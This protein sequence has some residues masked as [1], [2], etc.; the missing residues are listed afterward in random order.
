MIGQNVSDALNLKMRSY[1]D[2][3][4]WVRGGSDAKTV[5]ALQWQLDKSLTRGHINVT[6]TRNEV[7]QASRAFRKIAERAESSP[8]NAWM[9]LAEQFCAQFGTLWGDIPTRPPHIAQGTSEDWLEELGS[10]LDAN[11][12]AKELRKGNRK[13]R[14]AD[15]IVFI[16]ETGKAV[17]IRSNGDLIPVP[18]SDE[19]FVRQLPGEGSPRE[20]R[21]PDIYRHG[22]DQQKLWA[23][24]AEIINVQLHDRLSLAI[25]P[26]QKGLPA[27]VPN[28][29]L[30]TMYARLW[31]DIVTSASDADLRPVRTCA[32]PGCGEAL[33]IHATAR[34]KYCSDNCRVMHHRLAT[35]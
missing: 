18:G 16:E 14:V 3:F 5:F 15:R 8:D 30:A 10:F 9:G 17:F 13:S 24:F 19:S 7:R 11:D 6:D 1:P 32:R 20:I 29:A 2:G 25:D 21:M 33:P 27:I 23:Y 28:G 22:S 4:I 35:H 26:T 12:L 31:L 34:R